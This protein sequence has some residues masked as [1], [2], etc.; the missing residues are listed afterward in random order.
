MLLIAAGQV[1]GQAPG[2]AWAVSPGAGYASSTV[3]D[4]AG[5]VY[6]TGQSNGTAT[7]GATTFF[8]RD[9]LFVAKYD[10]T[11][12]CLWAVSASGGQGLAEG[13]SIA[14]DG[15]GNVYVTGIFISDTIRFGPIHLI[16]STGLT[17][18]NQ[19][20]FVAKLTPTGTW[21]WAVQADGSGTE[22][23]DGV[24][25]DDTGNAYVTGYFDGPTA[26]FGSTTLLNFS[27]R[28]TF[29]AKLTPGGVW[30]WATQVRGTFNS[31]RSVAVD[32]SGNLVIAGRF[33][34]TATFGAT[35][36]TS[37]GNSDVFVAKL[38]PTGAWQSGTRAG[39]SGDD[40]ATSLTVD[41][42]GNVL[43]GGEFDSDTAT[44]GT[45]TLFNRPLSSPI[46]RS[47]F[48]AKLTPVGA[49]QW[50]V[51]MAG[52]QSYSSTTVAVDGSG[53]VAVTG[54]FIDSTATFGTTVLA[55]TSA[56]STDGFVAKLTAAGTWLWAVKLGGT[57]DDIGTSVA[58]FGN[59]VFVSGNF[60][61]RIATFGTVTITYP[62]S[63]VNVAYPFFF[64]A[65]LGSTTGLPE[66]SP[67][68]SFTLAPNPAHHTATLTGA[69]GATA[70]LLDGLGRTVRTVPLTQGTATLDLRGLAPGLYVVRAGETARRLVVE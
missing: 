40:E 34:G 41:G 17:N 39:G 33:F 10:P 56:D 21:Q 60:L 8:G 53:N 44:F 9:L 23:G 57:R 51:R 35:M 67:N 70:I 37:A 13:R 46:S 66:S 26:T 58:F 6:V 52:S 65:R 54:D 50:A 12:T 19:N 24:A 64:I 14:V 45:A 43:V 69:A 55:N 47:R 68:T 20:M 2:W 59:D 36:L 18:F 1:M 30:Q 31:G 38:T 61:S 63:P 29:V 62:G 4:A 15:N 49:W 5:N 22:E 3:A 42:S 27:N 11:G 16:N 28:I 25:V 48:V 7:F 32:N